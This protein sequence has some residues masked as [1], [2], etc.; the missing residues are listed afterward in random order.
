MWLCLDL[1][2]TDVSKERINSIFRVDDAR[3][4]KRHIPEYD[5]LNS[6][7]C[8]NLKFYVVIK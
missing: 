8:E 4:T 5:I 2:S 1:A 3:S 7:R 6:H